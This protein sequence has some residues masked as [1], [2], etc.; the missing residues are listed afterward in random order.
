M[1]KKILRFFGS[2]R[3]ALILLL[4]LAAACMAGSFFGT[5]DIFHSW[6][7]IL[8][9][10]FLCIN[11]LFCNVVRFPSVWRRWQRAYREDGMITAGGELVAS[12]PSGNTAENE[13]TVTA[14]FQQLGFGNPKEIRQQEEQYLAAARNRNGIW[15]AW[16]CHLGILILIA[17]FGFGQMMKKEYTVYGVPGQSKPIGDTSCILTIDDFRIDL[18][19]DDTVEQYTST[20]T[21]HNAADGSSRSETVQVNHPASMYGMQ[22]YQNSTGWAADVHIEKDGQ[23]IQKDTLCTG[24]YTEVEDKEGLVI[25]FAAFYPDY[26][27]DEAGNMISLSS[28][29]SNPAYLYRVYYQGSVIGMNILMADE[30]ITIDEYTVR[31]S[32]PQPYTLIQVKKDPFTPVALIG[33]LLVLAGLLLSFY[34]QPQWV[35]AKRSIDGSWELYARSPKG[36]ALFRTRCQEA[37]EKVKK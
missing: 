15:G 4:I 31:F 7:F 13:K 10:L 1:G 35:W 2:M 24:E 37:L 8:I 29:L 9:T 22:F 32:D 33:G 16:V 26:A 23:E 11:L 25:F 14:W 34:C 27:R 12:L 21:V 6:W 5:S 30:V 28:A 20:L 3:F 36:G 19:E 18:R 17:G